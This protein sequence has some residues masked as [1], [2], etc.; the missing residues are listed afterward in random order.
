MLKTLKNKGILIGTIIKSKTIVLLFYYAK[1]LYWIK[2]K[3]EEE[4]KTKKD[5]LLRE[6]EKLLKKEFDDFETDP[7]IE[8]YKQKKKI[9]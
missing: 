9:K 6:R 3:M 2:R 5:N 7:I 8:F 4:I 1:I